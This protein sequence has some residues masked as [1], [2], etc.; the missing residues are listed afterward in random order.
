MEHTD[1]F[2]TLFFKVFKWYMYNI[3]ALYILYKILV[4]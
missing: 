4:G 3:N 2:I 1:L